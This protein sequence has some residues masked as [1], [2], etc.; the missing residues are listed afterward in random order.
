MQKEDLKTRTFRFFSKKNEKVIEMGMNFIRTR[1]IHIGNGEN[2]I[3]ME[4]SCNEMWQTRNGMLQT[5][6]EM[7]KIR[8]GMWEKCRQ[9]RRGQAMT[10]EELLRKYQKVYGEIVFPDDDINVLREIWRNPAGW[11][12]SFWNG[13]EKRT[14]KLLYQATCLRFCVHRKRLT[15]GG[16]LSSLAVLRRRRL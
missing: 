10:A 1:G 2:S 3:K 7:W 14:P 16:R 4:K 8:N 15:S 9:M 5:C 13:Q 6:N 12:Y 11:M